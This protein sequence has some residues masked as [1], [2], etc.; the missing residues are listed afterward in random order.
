MKRREHQFVDKLRCTP[1][2]K[3]VACVLVFGVTMTIAPQ[4]SWAGSDGRFIPNILVSSTNP[5]PLHPSDPSGDL[6]PYGV[7]FVP[8]EF[9][10]GGALSPGDVLG[11]KL[12]Q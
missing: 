10:T 3:R 9:P 2:F 12:Q 7:A 8:P 5:P 1:A 4:Q 6:N 11:F